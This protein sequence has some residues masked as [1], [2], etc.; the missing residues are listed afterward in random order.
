MELRTPI[1]R[2]SGRGCLT[3][4]HADG[5]RTTVASGNTLL[6]GFFDWL[7]SGDVWPDDSAIT[8]KVG[9]SKADTLVTNTALAEV[10]PLQSG[11]WPSCTVTEALPAAL[12]DDGATI[13][14]TRKYTA[15]FSPGQLVTS[16][17]EYGLDFGGSSLPADG[18]VHT[19]A[20][21]KDPDGTPSEL[22]L[23]ATDQL[24]A[25][26]TIEMRIP[27]ADLIATVPVLDAGVTTDYTLTTRFGKLA[28]LH[29]YVSLLSSDITESTDAATLITS[30][31]PMGPIGEGEVMVD[32]A[33]ART[34]PLE[35]SKISGQVSAMV[36]MES[37]Q[38]NHTG[39]I[40]TMVIG[41]GDGHYKFSWEPPL[42]KTA[43]KKVKFMLTLNLAR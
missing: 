1:A 32:S 4:K 7:A 31:G 21:V 20:L 6:D 38:C 24:I 11:V 34:S 8:F 2:M 22:V 36:T 13:L 37:E 14:A 28:P 43:A 15:V 27:A 29:H 30:D 23:T 5:T 26:Y 41:S 40:R 9:S 35:L 19:R 10:A 17:S 16:V 3:A 25:E 12:I 39:G 42:P 33:E 18:T